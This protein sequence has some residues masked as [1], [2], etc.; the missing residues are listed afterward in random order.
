MYCEQGN[1]KIDQEKW[2]D[3]WETEKQNAARAAFSSTLNQ[4]FIDQKLCLIFFLASLS[5]SLIFFFFNFANNRS[6]ENH[7]QMLQHW[8]KSIFNSAPRGWNCME[9]GCN[10]SNAVEKYLEILTKV[11]MPC[12]T[13][14]PSTHLC[15]PR[16]TLNIQHLVPQER[17]G[18]A[19]ML[20]KRKSQF[21]IW[22][23]QI[24]NSPLSLRQ[25]LLHS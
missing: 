17:D 8:S 7:S 5:A 12:N 16:Q 18:T 1:R 13:L 25:R 6:K 4:H 22:E 9:D 14:V 23:I 11:L 20:R 10:N 24:W 3:L 21:L 15:L 2:H 19:E